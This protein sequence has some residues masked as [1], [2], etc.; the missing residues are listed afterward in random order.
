MTTWAILASGPSMSQEVADSVRGLPTIAVSNTYELAPWADVLVSND[1]RWWVNYPKSLEFAGEKICGL[2]IEPPNGVTKFAGAMSGSNSGLLALMVAVKKGATRVLLFG[3]DM[4]G[5][6]YF[7][8]HPQPLMN[9]THVRFK[10][11]REQFAAYKPS[12]VEIINCTVNSALKCYKFGDPKDY[13]PQ[14][15]PEPEPVIEKDLTGPIGPEGPQG[16]QGERGPRGPEGP[17]GP[18]GPMPDHQWAGTSLRFEEPDGTWGKYVDL[19]GPAGVQGVPGGGGG[20]G[21]TPLQALQ[22][23]T[24]LDIFG[25]WIATPPI[26]SID[27]VVIDN[28]D[29]NVEGS[30]TGFYPTYPFPGTPL[31]VGWEWD[32]GDGSAHAATQDASHTY[33]EAST[34]TIRFRAK[35]HIG[36]SDWVEEEVTVSGV[37]D[38]ITH[39]LDSP[40]M[41]IT[42]GSSGNIAFT[43]DVPQGASVFVGLA[44]YTDNNSN[45]VVQDNQGNTLTPVLQVGDKSFLASMLYFVGDVDASSG[46]E[47][48]VTTP[49]TTGFI[50]GAGTVFKFDAGTPSLDVSGSTPDQA[51]T[52]GITATSGTSTQAKALSISCM[53]AWSF[54]TSLSNF[55][56]AGFT[57]IWHEFPTAASQP[58]AMAYRIESTT[59]AKSAVWSWD[60]Q[61]GTQGNALIGVFKA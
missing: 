56:C 16:P 37:S 33:A 53:S 12:G 58:G 39:I 6:H 7:G 2:C 26:P 60:A 22:L 10:K 59:G 47:V 52:S 51:A 54:A 4:A 19:R 35:N 1:R 36:W 5:S 8:D 41:R 42:G 11:F 25:G 38:A 40:I 43:G 49:G 50:S 24:M 45:P 15:E 3:F 55:D 29:V 57:D 27:E 20:Q 23:Q 44:V 13:L 9:P 17:Q 18:I 34:Y 32:W 14:P 61:S 28:L 31:D 21:M 46:Y 30:A 48:T